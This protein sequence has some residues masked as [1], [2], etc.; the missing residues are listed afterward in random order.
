M[1][2]S[3]LLIDGATE[4]RVE[5]AASLVHPH[6]LE[7]QEFSTYSLVIDA[8][9][10]H[11]FD[12][13]HIP[14]AV[15]LPVVDDTEYAEVGT[16]HKTDKHAAYGRAVDEPGVV[17]EELPKPEHRRTI[18]RRDRA[19]DRNTTQASHSRSAAPTPHR[20][21]TAASSCS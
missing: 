18:L 13:D 4:S 3:S 10:P 15:N 2:Y 5:T 19:A 21:P 12:E 8:Q 6:Q 9:S 14:G 7:V 20:S 17:A 11:E 16:T 1:R